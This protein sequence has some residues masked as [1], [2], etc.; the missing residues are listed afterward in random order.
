MKRPFRCHA[1][2]WR[3]WGIE[4]ER[5]F[6]LEDVRQADAPQ[7]DLNAI[8]SALEESRRKGANDT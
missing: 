7:P 3:G 8:N 1:C 5:S 6:S 2:N 4:T